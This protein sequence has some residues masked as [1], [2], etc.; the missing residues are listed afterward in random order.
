[1]GRGVAGRTEVSESR[2]SDPSKGDAGWEEK[3]S[4]SPL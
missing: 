1:M 3:N 4:N 2:E